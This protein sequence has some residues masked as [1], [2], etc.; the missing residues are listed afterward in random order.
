MLKA[1]DLMSKVLKFVTPNESIETIS[2][3]MKD[4]DLGIVPVLD[5]EHN[6]L[7][8]VTDRDIVIRNIAKKATGNNKKEMT[9]ED[10]MTR[11]VVTASPDDNIYD[12]SKIM[13]LKK[14]RRIPIVTNNKL[15]GIVSIA[16][17]A[18]TRKFDSEIAEAISEISQ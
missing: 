2:Q 7:G 6:L 10:I 18:V 15:V 14:I 13:A 5:E 12:I 16:D 4:C 9:A 3:I 17:I 1:K 8:V 11:N